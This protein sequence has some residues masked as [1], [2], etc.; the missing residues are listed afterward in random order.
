MNTP[1]NNISRGIV[2]AGVLVLLAP[3]IFGVSSLLEAKRHSSIP[4]ANM[5]IAFADTAPWS[6]MIKIGV[7]PLSDDAAENISSLLQFWGEEN[8][9]HISLRWQYTVVSI[10]I[11]KVDWDALL[12]NGRPPLF[13]KE[14]AVAGAFC[15]LSSF[16]FKGKHYQVVG[17]L[18][19]AVGALAFSYVVP[20]E[21]QQENTD[22]W[23]PAWL[24]PSGLPNLQDN[25]SIQETLDE[26]AKQ[27]VFLGEDF[28]LDTDLAVWNIS[29]LLLVAYGASVLWC[30]L[31]TVPSN[32]EGT[33][34]AKSLRVFKD[35]HLLFVSMHF[36]L[37][38]TFFAFLFAGEQFP[39]LR[40]QLIDLTSN[41]FREGNLRFIGHAY[42]S[43]DI[44]RASFATWAWNFGAATLTLTVLPS[45][46]IPF[47]GLAKTLLSFALVGFL[48]APTWSDAS[49]HMSYHCITMAVEFEAYIVV[50]FATVLFP[51]KMLKGLLSGELTKSMREILDVLTRTTLLSATILAVAAIYEA[52]TIILFRGI[53]L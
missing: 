40:R 9:P 6:E 37:Y 21:S 38:G 52:S 16:D 13:G 35:H 29:A 11:E 41:M 49:M 23:S 46:L 42:E 26:S 43:G 24:D 33:F 10:P 45:L 44:L 3:L 1:F 8:D 4:H 30:A 51:W 50:C 31:F 22:G 15:D 47:W 34:W 12:D 20:Y 27:P 2:L 17:K 5:V 28:P 14:E 36:I 53:S 39:L 25:A 18:K 48:M 32:T 19:R 7:A